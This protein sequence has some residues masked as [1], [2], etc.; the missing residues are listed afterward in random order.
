MVYART[1]RHGSLGGQIV[2][3]SAGEGGN[4]GETTGCSG[5][6][7]YYKDTGCEL[8]PRCTDSS[9]FLED[10]CPYPISK[11]PTFAKPGSPKKKCSKSI[12]TYT[13]V[14]VE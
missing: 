7:T 11:C 3:E 9:P 4:G 14:R 8:W 13:T 10:G 2:T 12:D 1:S 6:C 5:W